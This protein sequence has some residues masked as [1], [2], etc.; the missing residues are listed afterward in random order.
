MQ[1]TKRTVKKYCNN[2]IIIIIIRYHCAGIVAIRP[3]AGTVQDPKKNT[4]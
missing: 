1:S 3:F 4:K 2:I